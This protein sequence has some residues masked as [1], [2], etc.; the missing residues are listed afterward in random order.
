MGILLVRPHKVIHKV[1][2]IFATA[3][4]L[5]NSSVRQRT[6]EGDFRV[7]SYND[8]NCGNV[9]HAVGQISGVFGAVIHYRSD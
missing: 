9:Q 6:I 3:L 1:I 5:L 2:H 8:G 7:K 4:F